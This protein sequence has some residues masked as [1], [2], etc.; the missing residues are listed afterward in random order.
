MINFDL[1]VCLLIIIKEFNY[2]IIFN[3]SIAF[4]LKLSCY[5]KH[6]IVELYLNLILF[7]FKSLLVKILIWLAD[8]INI[9]CSPKIH[10]VNV[11]F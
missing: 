6:F 9:L 11:N 1:S 4:P 7:Y 10:H 3:L 2:I 8:Q 5:R